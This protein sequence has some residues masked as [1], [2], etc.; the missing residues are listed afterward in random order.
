MLLTIAIRVLE[1][2]FV[3]GAVGSAIVVILSAFEDFQT[4]FMKDA[5]PAPA[6]KE[7][8]YTAGQGAANLIRQTLR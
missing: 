6:G 1:T 4:L 8:D 3:V 7:Q 5:K 2:M